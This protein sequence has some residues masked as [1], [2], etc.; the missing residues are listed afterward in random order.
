MPV[1]DV[2]DV[3]VLPGANGDGA[4]QDQVVLGYP[5]AF[6]M[7]AEIANVLVVLRRQFSAFAGRCRRPT[8]PPAR[9]VRRRLRLLPE[10]L[11]RLTPAGWAS[12]DGLPL[13]NA[14]RGGLAQA[15]FP[16][17][18]GVLS[19]HGKW[20]GWIKRHGR[21]PTPVPSPK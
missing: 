11:N 21:W 14:G 19:R 6:K 20:A 13:G 2:G 16:V 15:G 3:L 12:P 4:D 17:N 9:S 10:G 7:V 1:P 5:S 8:L 18:P